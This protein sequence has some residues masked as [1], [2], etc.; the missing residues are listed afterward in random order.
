[1]KRVAAS[2]VSG[3]PLLAHAADSAAPAAAVSTAGSLLQVFIG[4]VAVLFLIAATAWVAKRFGVTRGGASNVLQVI[5]SVSV[6]ARERVVVVEVGESWLVVGVASGSVNGL[7]TLPRGEL[8]PT[9][10][11]AFNASFAAGLQQLIEKSPLGD[12]RRGK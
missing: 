11:P 3:L 2:V 12:K 7:M 8:Q 6:G 4:L 5:S 10:L 9:P 1:M